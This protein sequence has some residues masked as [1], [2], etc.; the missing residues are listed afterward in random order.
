M[1]SYGRIKEFHPEEESIE[2]YLERVELFFTANEVANEKKVA[3]FLSI[4]GS[5]TYAI[6]RNL[7]APAKPSSKGF[8]ALCAQ[9]KKHF[10]PS[11]IV[12]AERFH[13]HRRSQGPEEF[14]SEFLAEL[15]R[16][17]THCS[18]GEFLNDALRDRL[19]CGLHSE[20]I[21]RRLL[22][23]SDLTLA[24]AVEIAKGMEAATRDTQ[25]L[26]GQAPSI[27][28]VQSSGA[29]KKSSGTVPE[30]Q[31]HR[32]G[33]KN[34]LPHQCHF[35]D[36]VCHKCS[37]RGH[38]AKV[39]RAAKP[40][41]DA[42]TGGKRRKKTQWVQADDT[43]DS[44][45]ELPVLKVS[46]KISHPI[47]VELKIHGKVLYMEVDTGAAVSIISEQTKTRLFPNILLKPP[48]VVLRTYTGEALSVLGE[49]EAKVEYKDQSHNLTVVVVKGDGP[50]LFG[51]DWLSHFQLD[52]KTI[53][54][55][56]LDTDLS[57]VQLLKN[58][59]K[60]VFAD[61]LGTMKKF[62]AHLHV[63]S[64]A[65]PVFHRPRAVP[66]A[67]RDVIEKELERLEKEGIVERV[68]HSEWAAPIVPV[69]KGMARYVFVE[70]IK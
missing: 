50:N 36:V 54:I 9:L 66:Y 69:P 30:K 20:S 3:V 52:W 23:Q 27:K 31:C 61:G 24:Q 32:C 45:T 8:D 33:K 15:R 4:I 70:T 68:K 62:K 40:K 19:V 13:F 41:R 65:K 1:T 38:I 43:S 53:G 63:K 6:L 25:E 59:Y 28:A 29:T 11:K 17:A 34:H 44:E 12:I 47:R 67:I 39:C 26:Q 49:M 35:K 64:D 10:Q 22:S 7:V 57:Q 42:A 5:K 55:A 2:S 60:Q 18:F 48:S 51:R 14:I 37:K 46:S 21:Q 56:T 16:L 58:K